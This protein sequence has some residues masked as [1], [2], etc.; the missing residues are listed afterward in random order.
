[1]T[2]SRRRGLARVKELL[3][4]AL[5]LLERDAPDLERARLYASDAAELLAD[6]TREEPK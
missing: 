6:L 3:G 1:M 4:T 2:A 5:A